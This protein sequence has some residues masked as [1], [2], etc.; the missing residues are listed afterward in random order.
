MTQVY[1]RGEAPFHFSH[2]EKFGSEAALRLHRAHPAALTMHT[3]LFLVVTSGLLLLQTT[4]GLNANVEPD[5]EFLEEAMA[6][7]FLVSND[8]KYKT[9]KTQDKNNAIITHDSSNSKEKSSLFQKDSVPTETIALKS[10]EASTELTSENTKELPKNENA[11]DLITFVSNQTTTLFPEEKSEGSGNVP[12]WVLEESFLSRLSIPVY[13]SEEDGESGMGPEAPT[14]D[15]LTT[16]PSVIVNEEVIPKHINNVEKPME[17][18]SPEPT[19][20]VSSPFKPDQFKK[21]AK[22]PDALVKEG[23]PV[24]LLILALCLTLGAVICVF[25]GIATKDMWYGPSKK[26]LSIDSTEPKKYEEYDKAATL[27]LSEKEIVALMS[28][29]KTEMKETDYTMIS[30]EEVPEKEYL[31]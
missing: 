2:T 29:Q 15:W 16:I 22:E 19:V 9:E 26:C 4:Q 18:S 21:S 23:T 6:D 8:G 12:N 1:K 30:L 7:G 10:P 17:E 25:V 11:A 20:K 28:S 5:A 13:G 27:P 24:W 31:M 3:I 14:S